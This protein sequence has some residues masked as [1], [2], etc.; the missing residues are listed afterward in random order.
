MNIP[1]FKQEY[2]ARK[3][4]IK[5]GSRKSQLALIQTKHVIECLKEL[6]PGKTYEIVKMS[7]LGD[8]ILDK[9]LPKIGEKSLFTKEL[10]IALEQQDVDF[11]VH[12]LKDLPT[13]L[14]DGMCIGA[15]LKDALVLH[16]KHKGKSLKT[17]PNGSVIGECKGHRQ[18]CFFTSEIGVLRLESDEIM[19]A[20]GQ[21]ALAIECRED[22]FTTLRLLEPL[23]HGT[24]TLRVLAERSFLRTLGGGC[25]APVAVCSDLEGRTL[26][27]TGA[28]W[29][30]DGKKML[31]SSMT[32]QI[33]YR[34]E[35]DEDDDGEPP[36][37]CPYRMPKLFCS[38]SPGKLTYTDLEKAEKLGDDLACRLIADGALD[39]MSEAKKQNEM[40]PP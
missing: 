5:I 28:V 39:I 16:P 33:N 19:Y 14:P 36:R 3:D 30:L 18:G 31:K 4:T 2:P 22:D 21:G 29:T 38:I 40:S 12:S 10:E 32:C 26:S 8:Q 17:L 1:Y 7:T 25:S 15:I 35:E 6:N 37:K 34:Q 20:V 24:T 11:V 23:F 27:L 9:P 13:A